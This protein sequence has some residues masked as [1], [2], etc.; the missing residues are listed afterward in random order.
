MN[1]LPP[2]VTFTRRDGR[3]E[4]ILHRSVAVIGPEKIELKSA[5]GTVV[6]PLLG[7]GIAVA[8]MAYIMTDGADLP[9]WALVGVLFVCLALVPFSVMGLVS[10]LVGADVIIDAKKGSAMWQQGYLG[11][12]IGTKELV[13]FA[14][15]DHLEV[16]VEG[17]EADR[18]RE[19]SDDLRQFALVLVKKSGKR[20][21]CA[22]VPVP[23]YGQADGMDRT[24]AVAKAIADLTGSTVTIPEGWELVE[25]DTD[26]GEQ[27]TMEEK[28]APARAGA[29]QRQRR[30]QHG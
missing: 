19:E 23:A 3:Q 28:A 8:L 9:F 18:W 17:D 20:L 2:H 6:L 30:K 10:A 4:V 14:K 16:T 1:E 25:I 21:T 15:I 5:R 27:L 11:M 26:T 29:G 22:Q 12:G 13:P 7:I 24:L